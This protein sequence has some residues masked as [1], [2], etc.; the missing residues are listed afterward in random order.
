MIAD[1]ILVDAD[2]STLQGLS[3]LIVGGKPLT[4]RRANTAGDASATLQTLIQQQ[5][6]ALVGA[7]P[8]AA[9]TAAAAAVAALNAAN[10]AAAAVHA[11]AAAA[12][13]GG[14][15]AANPSAVPSGPTVVRLSNMVC[16]DDLV[17]DNEYADLMED[18]TQEVGK[19]GKLVG[20]EIPR[21]PEGGGPEPP[22][23]GF[24]YL[25]YEDPRGAER[26]QV[27]LNGRKF[28]DNLAEA[29]FYDRARFDAKDLE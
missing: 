2:V 24:V 7:P 25:C 16:T 26:A 20:V 29:T 8:V 23:V 10:A 11:Q 12:A 13:N 5:Q 15:N 14:G 18:V 19:Y 21:P 22:G 27:A 1:C 4:V 17:D 9:A 28:G 6:A 3:A